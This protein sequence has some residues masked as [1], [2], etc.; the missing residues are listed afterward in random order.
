M[1]MLLILAFDNEN[2]AQDMIVNI[3]T[4]QRQQMLI[5]SDA[6]L[7]IRQLDEKV[8]VK[9]VNSLVGSGMWGGAFWGFLVG[10]LFG[11]PIQGIASR[12]AVTENIPDC[13]LGES[14]INQIRHTIKL[15]NSALFLM[16]AHV[17]K[18]DFLAELAEYPVKQ[19]RLQLSLED[20]AKMR[21]AFGVVEEY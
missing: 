21:D 7:V 14:F 4:F 11:Q 12:E 8:K 15:G 10:L 6:A 13:G 2:G 1:D 9:Q 20:E 19:L 3:Q 17:T 16:I 5:V 18:D